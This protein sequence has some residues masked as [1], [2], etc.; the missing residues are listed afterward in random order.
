MDIKHR[1]DEIYDEILEIRR[2]LHAHP[3]LSE[4]EVRTSHKIS[5]Y[6]SSLKINHETGVA[7][8]GIIATIIGKRKSIS[9]Q[10]F[11][12]VAIRADMDALPICEMV[13]IPFRSTTEGVMHACGHDIHTAIMLGA[14]KLIKE[15]EDK[16]SGTVKFFFQPSEETIGGAMRMI[17]YGCMENPKVDAVIGLHVSPYIPAGAVEFCR[18]KMNAASTEF[19]IKVDGISCHGAHPDNGVDPI[20]VASQI[21]TS[22]QSIVSRNISPTNPAVVTIGQFHSGTK[23]NI[24]PAQATLSGIIRVLDS[25]SQILV[26]DRVETISINTAKALGASAS[27]S[28][29]D[30][31]PTLINDDE[32]EY[33][34]ENVANKHFEKDQIFFLPKPSMGA[35]DFSYFSEISKAVY[36]NIGTKTKD[37]KVLQSLHSEYYNPDESCIKSGLLMEVISVLELLNCSTKPA[38]KERI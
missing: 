38:C 13:D 23:D 2:D 15:L 4:N 22:L 11:P 31:Y 26:K 20:F 33:I 36:F 21:I 25:N 19:K 8:Y 34:I 30:S 10:R 3:E 9:N 18:G 5:A 7:G 28:F 14:A 17:E 16:I 24:I 12:V 1:I 6:L 27:V 35:E 32:L 29:N 37:E